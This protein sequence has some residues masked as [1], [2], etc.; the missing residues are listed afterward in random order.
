MKSSPSRKDSLRLRLISAAVGIP[1]LLALVITGPAS[2]LFLAAVAVLLGLME[3]FRLA[4]LKSW[5][6]RLGGFVLA[7]AF[8]AA[9]WRGYAGLLGATAALSPFALLLAHRW[10]PPSARPALLA[11]AGPLYLGATL[12]HG[13]LLRRL[14][15]GSKLL[16][17]A[18]LST[19]AIDTAAYF[20]GRAIG[21]HK[22]APKISPGK[23]WEGAIGG[24]AAGIAAA[25]ALA[26]AFDLHVPLWKAAG[27]GA[28]LGIVGQAGD[29]LESAL[30]RAHQAKDAGGLIPGHGGIL[31]RL[32][33]IVYNLVVVYH[34]YVWGTS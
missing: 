23:T 28:S 31:D 34:F 7:L 2:T 27:I 19:F 22:L 16:L 1:A 6:L 30:K 18:I 11:L 33:S 26:F 25:V 29:L 9:G 4:G 12:A 24:F 5:L 15:Q 14:D 21:R 3:F 17:L 10:T 20:V 13:I 32:D 8:V